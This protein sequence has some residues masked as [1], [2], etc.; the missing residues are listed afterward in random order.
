[1]EIGMLWFDNDQKAS[2]P[3]KVEKAARY[4]QEK[5]GVNPNLCYVHP[6]TIKGGNGKLK[7]LRGKGGKEPIHIGRILVLKNDKVLPDHFW[8]GIRDGGE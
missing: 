3:S 5:Y 8:I 4:Y 1:M 6:K 2:I 7:G